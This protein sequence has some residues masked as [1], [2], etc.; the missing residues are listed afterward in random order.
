MYRLW[1]RLVVLDSVH[2]PCQCHQNDRISS[3]LLILEGPLLKQ[4][5]VSAFAWLFV[6]TESAYFQH[7]FTFIWSGPHIF[8]VRFPLQARAFLDLLTVRVRMRPKSKMSPAVYLV[9]P[10][11]RSLH[12]VFDINNWKFP[13]ETKFKCCFL[14]FNGWRLQMLVLTMGWYK[15]IC[16]NMTH[17]YWR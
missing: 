15:I 16:H 6:K 14:I 2:V 8:S 1:E 7:C 11:K 17:G 10:L 13:L 5:F 4:T 12:A 3:S 9:F